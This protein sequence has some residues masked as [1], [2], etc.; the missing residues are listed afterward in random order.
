MSPVKFWPDTILA[1]KA[2]IEIG[3]VVKADLFPC[4]WPYLMRP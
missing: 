4:T 2:F 1:E 3:I